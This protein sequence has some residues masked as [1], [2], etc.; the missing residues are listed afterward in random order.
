VVY[1]D[2]VDVIPKKLNIVIMTTRVDNNNITIYVGKSRQFPIS[3]WIH[4]CYMRDPRWKLCGILRK[5]Y[6]YVKREYVPL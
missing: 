1:V 3:G 5:T 4:P 2:T 6:M